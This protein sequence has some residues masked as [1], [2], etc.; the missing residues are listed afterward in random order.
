MHFGNAQ[1]AG[2]N[3]VKT[4][5]SRSCGLAPSF[6]SDYTS[7]VVEFTDF[8]GC[9]LQ[10]FGESWNSLAIMGSPVVSLRK[11]PTWKT[12]TPGSPKRCAKVKWLLTEV[13]HVHKLGQPW[14]DTLV[15]H[16][17]FD[18]W[19]NVLTSYL[20]LAGFTGKKWGVHKFTDWSLTVPLKFVILAYIPFSD[21]P[22]W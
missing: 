17:C 5:F 22:I 4:M 7:D 19:W 20:F 8:Y 1:H 12:K 16:F 3:Q 9:T 15:L 14:S 13:F 11:W 10:L 18:Q 6:Q 2:V 21:T